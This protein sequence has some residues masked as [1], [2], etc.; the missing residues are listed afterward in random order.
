MPIYFGMK[1]QL[2]DDL[3]YKT[4]PIKAILCRLEKNEEEEK[5][6]V[7][8]ILSK[9]KDKIEISEWTL[10]DVGYYKGIEE[11]KIKIVYVDRIEGN[12]RDM[13]LVK[14]TNNQVLKYKLSL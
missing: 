7:L 11:I 6:F 2:F 5:I 8:S 3:P 9:Y 4:I 13:K 1:Y 12:S 10:F 14:A